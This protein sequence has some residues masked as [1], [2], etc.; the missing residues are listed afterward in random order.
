MLASSRCNKL[1]LH[2]VVGAYYLLRVIGQESLKRCEPPLRKKEERRRI[3][4]VI[5][6]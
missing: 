5:E 2:F 1:A 4:K 3:R 6:T